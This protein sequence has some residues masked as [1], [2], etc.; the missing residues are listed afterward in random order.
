[1]WRARLKSPMR[2]PQSLE[3]TGRERILEATGEACQGHDVYT[4]GGNE[5]TCWF[6]LGPHPGSCSLLVWRSVE[7]EHRGNTPPRLHTRS[8]V[9]PSREGPGSA[10]GG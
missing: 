7:A 5:A 3:P 6:E 8:S 2:S 1:M 10:S 4:A 9:L